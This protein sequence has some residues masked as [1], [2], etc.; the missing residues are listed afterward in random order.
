MPSEVAVKLWGRV[1]T[2]FIADTSLFLAFSFTNMSKAYCIFFTNNLMLPF[3]ARCFLGEKF[4]LW[5]VIGIIFGFG[6]MILLVQ[7]WVVKDDEAGLNAEESKDMIGCA[8]AFM[9]AV[10]A[11]SSLTI[12]KSLSTES[13]IHWKIIPLYYVI[14][15]S[16]YA[17][18]WSFLIPPVT[19]VDE[20]PLYGYG[21]YLLM[22]GAGACAML[23]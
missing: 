15:C 10:S 14:G 1:T 11:A 22:A 3:L 16:L 12:G 18:I 9:A 4:K 13:R 21:L 20:I 8:I 2:G 7:P 6:G 19:N 5:D 23:Q 17:P